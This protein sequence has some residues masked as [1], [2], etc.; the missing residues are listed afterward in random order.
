[1][2]I[3]NECVGDH[4]WLYHAI[5]DPPKTTDYFMHM[6][7]NYEIVCFVSGNAR[8]MVEGTVYVLFPGALLLMRPSESHTLV[9]GGLDRYE[10][11]TLNFHQEL[12]EKTGFSTSLLRPFYDRPLGA[13]N[14]YLPSELEG[15]DASVCFRK[16][17][18]EAKLL[19]KKEVLLANLA[20]L[21]CSINVAFVRKGNVV[22]PK[23]TKIGN[24]LI[25]YINENLLSDLSLTSLSA[26]IHMS[27]SQINRIFKESTGS[28]VYHYILL[29]RMI[30]AREMIA[31][32]ESAQTAAL[33]CGFRDY[34][35]FFRLYKKHF[36]MAPT[37]TKKRI[38]PIADLPHVQARQNDESD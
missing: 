17:C 18:E 16:I 32:G 20:S 27:P 4:F 34:S 31:N 22:T 1:M 26:Y 24:E 36:S 15:I 33:S 38:S 13:H 9:L 2:P 21:L 29:K 6:H 25:T 8:Y 19:P 7:D 37:S 30:L 5:D 12:F 28:S 3:A 10:R 11:F 35:S 14:L 23:Y